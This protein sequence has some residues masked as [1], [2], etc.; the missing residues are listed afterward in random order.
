MV[1]CID[2]RFWPKTLPLLKKKYG[3]FDLIAMAGASKNIAS[4]HTR[5][6]KKALLENIGIAIKIH[7]AK[8]IILTNHKDCGA[9]GGSK[10]FNSF[11]EE[12]KFHKSELEKARKIIRRK[13]PKLK[14]ETVFI[15]K[16][17]NKIKLL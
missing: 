10:K 17:K 15:V 11:E 9:Y 13:F 3:D 2:Y 4:P 5:E 16:D 6:D 8:K 7:K 1:N 12:F 14:I